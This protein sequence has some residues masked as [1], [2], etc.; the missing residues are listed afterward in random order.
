M[1]AAVLLTENTSFTF[2][3]Q[4]ITSLIM[5]V[6]LLIVLVLLLVASSVQKIISVSGASII[7]RVMG[8]IL[9]AMAVTNII[10]GIKASFNI[11][12]NYNY[13]RF[14]MQLFNP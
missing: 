7:S 14:S 1:L 3:E 12:S 9:T 8:L 10:E 13:I 5:M 2:L 6:V 4:L 11:L